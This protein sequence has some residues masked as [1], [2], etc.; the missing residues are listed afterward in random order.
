[1]LAGCGGEV[2]DFE[3]EEAT[4]EAEG[5]LIDGNALSAN[6]L[7][8]NAL[9]LNAL[10][11]NALNLNALDA[12]ALAA[13]RNA[14]PSGE[15]S[16]AFLRYAVGCALST[17][18]TFDF[19]WTDAGGVVH[20]ESYRG[21]LAV[22]PAWAN[23]PLDPESQYMVSACVAARVNYYQVP[24][25]I[26]IR[27]LREP[28]KTLTGSQ[29]LADYPDVEGAFWGNL[30]GAQPTMHACYNSAT[31][32][33][34]RSHKRDCAVGHVTTDPD[35]GAEITTE[36]GIIDIVGP[37][38]QFCQGLN[39]A[40]QYYPSCIQNP[41]QSTTTTKAVVTTALP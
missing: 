34:S 30:F 2:E 28:L 32:S 23:G 10:N 3:G 1:M 31:V 11:L 25:I 29:E 6:A 20:K 7:N 13:I 17:S 5:A 9:N 14:G 37:C 18:Q 21:E 39:G 8:L 36:C 16:R 22:A 12:G 41:G 40:G 33:N 26:S 38:S 24:V 27:S 35:T 15:M 4:A 19:S